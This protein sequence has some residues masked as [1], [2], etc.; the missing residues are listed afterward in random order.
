MDLVGPLPETSQGNKYIIT[1]TD[2]FSKWAEAAPLHDKTAASVARFMYS[3]SKHYYIHIGL[4][5]LCFN[6]VYV[7]MAALRLL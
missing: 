2:Y 1:I 3:V 6:S 4:T 5:M 7:D